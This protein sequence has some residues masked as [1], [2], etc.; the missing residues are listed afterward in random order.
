ML[1]SE[2]VCDDFLPSKNVSLVKALKNK[3]AYTTH[4][5]LFRENLCDAFGRKLVLG[6]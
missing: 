6:K 1:F 5:I 2:N 4:E 3:S